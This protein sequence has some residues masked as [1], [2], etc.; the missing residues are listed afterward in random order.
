MTGAPLNSLE[1][2]HC[3]FVGIAAETGYLSA[4]F[5]RKPGWYKY[6]HMPID[7]VRKISMSMQV[8]ALGWNGGD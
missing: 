3:S 4:R 2:L 5:P 1:E 7:S 6:I 8:A